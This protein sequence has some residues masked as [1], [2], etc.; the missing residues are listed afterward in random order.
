MAINF[1]TPAIFPNL[2]LDVLFARLSLLDDKVRAVNRGLRKMDPNLTVGIY[3]ESWQ[4]VT[5]TEEFNG[6]LLGQRSVSTL[7]E[8]YFQIHT[9][10]K[11]ADMTKGQQQHSVLC[12]AVRD[13]VEFD[14]PLKVALQSLPGVVL[15]GRTETFKEMKALSQVFFPLEEPSTGFVNI[16]ALRCKITTEIQIG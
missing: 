3:P 6:G 9:L 7:N 14:S 16:G 1:E 11:A 15:L 4:P 2:V 12:R 8:Y 5:D 13:V 10:V